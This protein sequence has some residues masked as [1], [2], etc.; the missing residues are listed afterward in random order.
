MSRITK[1]IVSFIALTLISGGVLYLI[2][3]VRNAIH[4]T[5]TVEITE[6]RPLHNPDDLLTDDQL[7]YKHTTFDPDLVDRRALGEWRVNLSDAVLALDVPHVRPDTDES[8]LEL[9]R[10]YADAIKSAHGGSMAVLPSVNIIDGKAKQ[11]DDGLYAALE[12]A[13]YRGVTDRFKSHVRLIRRIFDRVGPDNAAAPYL[14]AALGLAGE[15]ARATSASEQDALVRAFLA[16]PLSSKP[17][18]FY[19]WNATLT[20]CF[21]FLRFLQQPIRNV[22][23]ARAIAKA[24]SENATL[25]ADVRSAV[26]FYATLTNPPA[27]G[28]IVDFVKKVDSVRGAVPFFPYA[29]SRENE[30]FEKLFPAGLPPGADLMNELSSRIR[31]GA[32]ELKPRPNSGW[33]DYQVYALETLLLP[34]KADEHNKLLLSKSYKTRMLEAFKALVTKRRETH[35]RELGEP[36]SAEPPEPPDTVEPRLRLEPAPTYYLRTAR[37]YSFLEKVLVSAVGDN[38]FKSIQGL[39]EKGSRETDL[40]TELRAMRELFYGFYLLSAEDI[41][42]KPAFLEGENVD[43]DA[44]EARASVWLAKFESDRDLAA[45]T[46]VA[47]P[48]YD[49]QVQGMMRLWMTVGVRLTK[50]TVEFVRPPRTRPNNDSGEW[51]PVEGNRCRKVEYL[52]PVDE[53]AE[54]TLKGR[55]VLTREELRSVCNQY[56]TKA[57]IVEALE[58]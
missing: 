55:R 28:C 27:T 18:S 43:R 40:A 11:F 32:V 16:D 38:A 9:H 29:T 46:R 26:G 47:I 19:T 13:Y 21:R 50:L 36:K 56:K 45:D 30:L 4:G 25:L 7:E 24:L 51:Q 20:S 5:E 31:S 1:Y 35:V 57:A 42:L 12:Q 39:R 41:G 3:D 44:C 52:I 8:L 10:S 34:E 58:K 54:V 6:Y 37:G 53:F 15:T 22:K 14:A 2:P 17:I 33:Y 23:A 49:D 48:I